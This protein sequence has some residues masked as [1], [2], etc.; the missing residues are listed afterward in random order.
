[1]IASKF[2]DAP[3]HPLLS[4]IMKGVYKDA[5]V[6]H[7]D[8]KCLAFREVDPVTN[9]H[10][11]VIPK[12]E[13]WTAG[14]DMRNLEQEHKSLMGHLM[15]TAVNVAKVVGLEKGYRTLVNNGCAG[16]KP[17]QEGQLMI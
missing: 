3:A 11:V 14:Q 17:H 1:M 6:L 5:T 12:P 15:V 13:V 7:E 9:I 16:V 2:A 10:F 8:Q 4:K